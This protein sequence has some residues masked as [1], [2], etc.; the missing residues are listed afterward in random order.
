[1]KIS[2]ENISK[3]FFREWIFKKINYH[4]E[5][6]S[7]YA[8]LGSN[9]SGKSTLLQ[10]IAGNILASSGS[11]VY[12]KNNISIDAAD[13]YSHISIV[14]PYLSLIEELNLEEHFNF[15][16]SFKQPIHPNL[17]YE[18]W[19]YSIGLKNKAHH[20]LISHFSSGM[21]QRVKL[22]LALYS[23]QDLLLLDEPTTNL[24]QEGI[25][26]YAHE[27]E[28]KIGHTTL[29][30]ASNQRD[31]YAMTQHLVTLSQWKQ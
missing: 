15:H 28:K 2:L 10:L 20:K 31:E 13:V 19:L 9:G 14:A 11:I 6:R 16:F 4:F 3:R 7:S 27:I 22:G 21:K 25:E 18:D 29:I 1:M 23:L 12:S 26:W 17:K 5:S 24:D 8:L 30:I